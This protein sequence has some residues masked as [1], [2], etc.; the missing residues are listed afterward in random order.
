[1]GTNIK[2]QPTANAMLKASVSYH[3]NFSKTNVG[4]HACDTPLVVL[5]KEDVQRTVYLAEVKRL[6]FD[7]WPL[8]PRVRKEQRAVAG[9]ADLNCAHAVESC[10]LFEGGI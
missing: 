8:G 7:K 3:F 2:T 6:H 9:I 5:T 4:E 10:E 1:M